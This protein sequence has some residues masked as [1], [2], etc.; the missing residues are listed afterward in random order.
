MSQYR[1][2]EAARL[3]GVSAANI[4]YYEREGLVRPSGRAEN[5]YRFFTDA[6]LHRLRFIRM[7]RALDMSLDE[8]RTLLALD[9]NSKEDCAAANA[10]VNGHLQ[11]VRE[12][13]HELQILEQE[14]LALRGRCDGS[15]AHC[16]IIEALHAQADAPLEE[17]RPRRPAPASATSDRPR[18]GRRHRSGARGYGRHCHAVVMLQCKIDHGC[19]AARC[20][21]WRPAPASAR[22]F[23]P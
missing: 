7:C 14:L 18:Q 13:L 20:L 16:H 12:R 11:H 8:V 23:N 21:L 22:V 4:R 19:V 2:G 10:T 3:S 15:D 9:L 1:I 6:D 5:D 17:A